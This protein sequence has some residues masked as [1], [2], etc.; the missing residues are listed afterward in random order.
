M[1]DTGENWQ[2]KHT[3]DIALII[4]KDEILNTGFSVLYDND[5]KNKIETG[6]CKKIF[7]KL[8]PFEKEN[9]EI[10]GF[11]GTEID[12]HSKAGILYTEKFKDK[13]MAFVE[14]KRT[15]SDKSKI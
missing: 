6:E 4:L 8:N 3:C 10:S 5:I 15:A 14:V 12:F 1:L 9:I 7:E 2:D 13:K 11:P